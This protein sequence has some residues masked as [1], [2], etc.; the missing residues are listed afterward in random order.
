MRVRGVEVQVSIGLMWWYVEPETAVQ[1]RE[2]RDAKQKGCR[3]Q[4]L[5]PRPG[6]RASS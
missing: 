4:E 6:A 1:G 3:S 2:G 5:G